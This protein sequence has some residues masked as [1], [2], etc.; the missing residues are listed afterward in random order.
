MSI[1][2][3]GQNIYKEIGNYISS[4]RITTFN[5]WQ[6]TQFTLKKKKKKYY[7]FVE[8]ETGITVVTSRIDKDEFQAN[9]VKVVSTFNYLTF[10]QKNDVL[11]TNL[12]N[13]FTLVHNDFINSDLTNYMLDYIKNNSGNLEKKI[14][15]QLRDTKK[16]DENIVLSLLLMNLSKEHSAK[17]IETIAWKANKLFPVKTKHPRAN[18]KYWDLKAEFMDPNHWA[19]YENH[20][21]SN[22][23]KVSNEIRQNNDKIID[24]YLR[25]PKENFQGVGIDLKE[26]LVDFVNNYLFTRE[27]RFVNSNLGDL[28]YYIWCCI[29]YGI[30]ANGTFSAEQKKLATANV[31]TLFYDFYRFLS[32]V[33]LI[34]KA[35]LKRVDDICQEQFE[36]YTDNYSP[37]EDIDEDTVKEISKKIMNDPEKYSR[38][39]NDPD[40][41]DQ[42][43]V[44]INSILELLDVIP[45]FTKYMKSKDKKN[46]GNENQKRNHAVYE[47]R[48]KLKGFRPSI[49]RRFII[50]GNSSV[51]TL[52]QAILLMFNVGWGHL[53]DLYNPKDDVHYE[54]QEENDSDMVLSYNSADSEKTKI[55]VFDEGDKLTLTYDYGDNWE[56]EVHIKKV[57]YNIAIPKNPQILS[58]KGYSIIEDIG[59]VW[60][61]QEY[62]DTPENK[63]DPDLLEEE[64]GSKTD[65]D[66]FDKDGLNELLKHPPYSYDYF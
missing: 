18:V 31:L 10:Q 63:L 42:L 38:I 34:T 12:T 54:N 8:I 23:E 62:Y 24:Q 3:Y 65:L 25:N 26:Q 57:S 9:L 47:I 4:K 33:G 52:M 1:I 15:S 45:D 5:D 58:G 21:I 43:K 51:E 41:P 59:G 30:E 60:S 27:L 6:L 46:A 20:D 56:F 55:S 7:L 44:L 66:E 37:S 29:Y 13:G 39:A 49:W 61:L 50:S 64:G 2:Q 53:Y 19:R 11:D 16:N 36:I 48:T 28:N 32:R 22:N 40:T 17:I 35:D 14:Q